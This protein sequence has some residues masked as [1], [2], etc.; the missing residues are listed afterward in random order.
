MLGTADAGSR[1]ESR[2]FPVSPWPAASGL[3]LLRVP[4]ASRSR[5]THPCRGAIPRLRSVTSRR[6]DRPGRVPLLP[7]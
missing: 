1:P 2:V 5:R 4:H 7:R 6:A 3:S